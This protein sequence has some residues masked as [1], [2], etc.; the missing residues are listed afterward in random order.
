MRA[1][2]PLVT[3]NTISEQTGAGSCD[4][5]AGIFVVDA[6]PLLT[7]NVLSAPITMNG[8]A[9]RITEL[10]GG[11]ATG[12]TLSRNVA[13]GGFAGLTTVQLGGSFGPISLSN[14]LLV[15]YTNFG[16]ESEGN[17]TATNVTVASS[18]PAVIADMDLGNNGDLTLDS[19]I[20]G[21][22]GIFAMAGSACFITFSRGPTTTGTDCQS[23]QTAAIPLFRNPLPGDYRLD[24]TS[25]LI[26][27]G[28]PAAP[29]AALDVGGNPRAL[30]GPK[31]GCP[32][33]PPGPA[34]RD[35]GA[36]EFGPPA[37]PVATPQC[38]GPA[39]G[40]DPDTKKKC[41]KPKKKGKKAKGKPRC[42]K[43]KKKP[44][45]RR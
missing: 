24:P 8:S 30:S 14:D 31:P 39:P 28:N 29:A 43:K 32:P 4:P 9:I 38:F 35:M 26:D 12:A 18:A 34:I 6:Q 41:L 23:F 44:K 20:V 45:K 5:C 27:A 33:A 13:R 11:V 19:S 3:S 22:V 15:D 36:Y 2:T 10:A 37:D 40:T 21:D 25:P 7:S 17:I 16:I 42:K 1:G